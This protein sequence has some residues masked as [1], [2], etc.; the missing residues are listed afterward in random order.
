MPRLLPTNTQK[1]TPNTP[2]SHCFLIRHSLPRQPLTS[3]SPGG[4]TRY[5][6]ARQGLESGPGPQGF[7]RND[8]VSSSGTAPPPYSDQAAP[9]GYGNSRYGASGGYASNSKYAGSSYSNAP[10]QGGYGGLGRTDSNSTVRRPAS[11]S[12]MKKD[13]VLTCTRTPTAMLFFPVPGIDTN[14]RRLRQITVAAAAA[15]VMA[16]MAVLVQV[17]L[18]A[19]TSMTVTARGGK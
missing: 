18:Q 15:A 1:T 7:N 3:N 8:S 16:A 5:Q 13:H 2:V 4:M 17:L 11:R 6:Q 12:P 14:S 10:R 9:T 19:T